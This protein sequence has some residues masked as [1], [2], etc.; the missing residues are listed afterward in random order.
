MDE[1]YRRYGENK[2]AIVYPIFLI[3]FVGTM[4]II[5]QSILLPKFETLFTTMSVE[6]NVFL[7]FVLAISAFLPRAWL[8]LIS[9]LLIIILKRFWFNKLCP[10]KQRMMILK[11]PV[12]GMFAR[13]YDTHFFASQFSGLL[14]GGFSIN[15]TIKLFAQNQRQPFY[16]KLCEQVKKELL[17]GKATLKS[18]FNSCLILIKISIL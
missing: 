7:V 10:L 6:Q 11:I 1:A 2:E 4:F 9:L 15:E 3:F 12:V 8:L 14:S 17:A 16:Q 13:L 5:L 18:F